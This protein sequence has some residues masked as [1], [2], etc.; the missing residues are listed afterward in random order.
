MRPREASPRSADD[1]Q[2]HE[3]HEEDALHGGDD[4][5][6]LRVHARASRVAAIQIGIFAIR[7]RK[8]TG[9]TM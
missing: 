8:L 1:D 2:R 5:E 3:Q 7:T 9:F 6:D 4:E